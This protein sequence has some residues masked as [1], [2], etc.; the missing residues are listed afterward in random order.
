MGPTSARR[1]PTSRLVVFADEPAHPVRF[2]RE[3]GTYRRP[4]R[5]WNGRPLDLEAVR[6]WKQRLAED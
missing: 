2:V 5:R 4:D 1:A 6:R 3:A